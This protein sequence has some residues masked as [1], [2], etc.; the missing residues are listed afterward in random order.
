[1]E[2]QEIFDGVMTHLH[3]QGKR[4]IGLDGECVYRGPNN[5]KCAVGC[6][7]PEELYN[8]K[9]EGNNVKQI[10]ATNPELQEYFGIKN[11]KLTDDGFYTDD[12]D[13]KLQLMYEMQVIHDT[14][15]VYPNGNWISQA[16]N[17]A[18]KYNLDFTQGE[19]HESD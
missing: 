1:M 4:A 12:Q 7:I 16:A 3:T 8:S 6:L 17:I 14:S 11:I 5:L 19:S 15:N 2:M 13:D 9:M 10:L 18:N